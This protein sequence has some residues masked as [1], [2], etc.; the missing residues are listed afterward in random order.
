MR[1][2][3]LPRLFRLP[4]LLR[5]ARLFRLPGMFRLPRVLQ[6]SRAFQMYRLLRMP[7]LVVRTRVLARVALVAST[8]APLAC[9][10]P[11]V[12]NGTLTCNGA[13][14]SIGQPAE[15]ATLRTMTT[16]HGPHVKLSD[17]FDDAGANADRVLGP[18]PVP[19]GRIVVEAAQLVAIAHQFAVEWRPA[20]SAD[21]AVLDW[22]G[23]PLPREVA[24]HALREALAASGLT[25][26]DCVIDLSGF[27]PPVV[28]FEVTPQ[29]LVSQLDYDRDSGRFAAVLSVASDGIE[30]INMRITGR[31]D[32]LVEVPVATARLPAGA[33][34]QQ[35]D[36]HMARVRA[37]VAN[38][39]VA[40]QLADAI[41]MQLRHQVAAGQPLALA[42]LSRPEMV[43]RGAE[44]MMLLD[45]PGIVLTAHGQAMDS[46]AIGERIHVMNPVSHALIEAE[47]IGANRVRVSPGALR[48]QDAGSASPR[49]G[50]VALQ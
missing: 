18:G 7:G 25:L 10:T 16:L 41:G 50:E 49:N 9:I 34:L 35:E 26:D 1:L 2:V 47:V 44:V 8:A 33:V 31:V 46:G 45:S 39:A 19:G 14:I 24:M 43:R 11:L 27:T 4:G 38:H 36:V 6:M 13:P 48:L 21:R 37:A 17:L 29:P 3:Q 42:D 40:R 32:E 30:P 28:P 23:R 20:S 12:C 15:A 22:P 5:L